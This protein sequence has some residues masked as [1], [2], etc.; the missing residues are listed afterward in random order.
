MDTESTTS[1]M[2]AGKTLKLEPLSVETG[3]DLVQEPGKIEG[4]LL[5]RRKRPLKGWHRVRALGGIL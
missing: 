4:Y 5:K 1:E 3:Q 2:D